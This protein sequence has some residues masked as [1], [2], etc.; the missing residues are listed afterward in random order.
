MDVNGASPTTSHTSVANA[1]V[2][3]LIGL[4]YGLH[5]AKRAETENPLDTAAR[6]SVYADAR[7]A[8]A[9]DTEARRTA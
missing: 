9:G 5:T 6:E 2:D 4:I 8:G 1:L 3:A 7:P